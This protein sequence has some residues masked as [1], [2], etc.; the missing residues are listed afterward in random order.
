MKRLRRASVVAAV[1][2]VTGVGLLASPASAAGATA[3]LYPSGAQAKFDN[4]PGNGAESWLWIYTGSSTKARANY[5][6]RDGSSGWRELN[7]GQSY[8]SNSWNMDKDIARIQVC[9]WNTSYVWSCSSWES[10]HPLGDIA[11][12]R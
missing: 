3:R 11:Y 4:S 1:A 12:G 10:W 9:A 5:V 7:W 6:N 8:S 2:A